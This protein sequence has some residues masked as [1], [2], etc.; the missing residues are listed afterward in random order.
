MLNGAGSVD[1]DKFRYC[2]EWSLYRPHNLSLGVKS[3][4][5]SGVPSLKCVSQVLDT[6]SDLEPPPG[7]RSFSSSDL[8]CE[9]SSRCLDHDKIRNSVT[10]FGAQSIAQ[11]DLQRMNFPAGFRAYSGTMSLYGPPTGLPAVALA[12]KYLQRKCFWRA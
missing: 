12:Q 1:R 11:I 3:P 6:T 2:R 10:S 4:S 9:R 8:Q 7:V 5:H